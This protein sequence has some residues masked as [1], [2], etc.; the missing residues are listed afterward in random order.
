[1]GIDAWITL[2]VVAVLLFALLKNLAPPDL[3]FLGATALLAV[4]GIITPDEAFAGFSNSGMLTVAVLFVVAAGLRETGVLDYVGHH[5]LGR[6]RTE[7][8][9]LTRLA[10]VVLPMSAFLNN[11]PVVAMFVPVVMD[12]SRRHQVSPSK[13]LIPLS[14]L[15]ILGGTCT[16]IGTSTNLVVN[17]LMIQNGLPGMRLFEIGMVGVPYAVIGLVYLFFA[18]RRLLPDRKELLEQLGESR[19]EY[20]AE[21]Q[22]QPGCRLIGKSVEGAGLRQLPGLFLIE[23]DRNGQIIGPVGPDD[24][25][26]AH[27]RLVF[28]GIVSSII[29][30]EMIPGLVPIADPAYEVSPKQQRGRRLCEAVISENS[31][32]VGKTIRDSDFRAI[33]GAAVVA[34]HRGGRRVEKKIGDITVRPGDTLLLQVRPHF[35]RAYRH[36]PAF[37]LVS[38]VDEWRPIRRDRAWIAVA[39]F[40]ALVVLMA[41]G[42]VPIVVAAA[43]IAVLMVAAGCISSG[44][45]RRSVEWQVL[46]TIAA[47]FGVGTA[48]Q[49]SGAATAVATTLVNTT[50]AGGPIVA[51]AVIYLLGSILTELITNNAAAVLLFPFC[52]ETAR[53]YNADPRPFLMALILSASASFMTPIGYQTNMMVYGPGGYRFTDFLRIGAP[54]NTCLWI[55]A[56]CL[57]PLLW[58]F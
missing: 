4:L 20:L 39:L 47:A 45:A 31:R 14:F 3:L 8:G 51:L 13:L 11:T 23:I 17:G 27:D 32:L 34:V 26:H 15:A 35:L 42:S 48:L 56:V 50:Q 24:V 2:T 22:V 54:L 5:V 28:T 49:N 43:L 9:V 40:L 12:W 33:Y 57:I 25:I 19:R 16:L 18:G 29:E 37:Y 44:E 21:M 52:L 53:L 7:A 1:M 46:V 10:A 58:P 55:V 41:T 30:L 38:D 36:D 6:A